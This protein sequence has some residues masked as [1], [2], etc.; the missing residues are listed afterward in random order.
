[1]AK[2]RIGSFR[3]REAQKIVVRDG[4]KVNI[5]SYSS[6]S[7]CSSILSPLEV[8]IEQCPGPPN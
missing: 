3:L 4:N 8:H 1:M 7:F 2:F 6:L 5:N